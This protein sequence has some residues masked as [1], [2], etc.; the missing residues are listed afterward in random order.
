[1]IWMIM[2]NPEDDIPKRDWKRYLI[3]IPFVL[4]GIGMIGMLLE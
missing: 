1:M 2:M 4:I 3:L